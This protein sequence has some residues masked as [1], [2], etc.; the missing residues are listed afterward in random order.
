M[1]MTTKH[2]EQLKIAAQK[3]GIIDLDALALADMN[4]DDG[5][6]RSADELVAALKQAKPHLFRPK[7][8][9][10]MSRAERENFLKEHKRK[11][12]L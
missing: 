5:T 6:A 4:K 10:D 11:F 1:T 9:R 7:M 2:S 8:A 12:N 3:A